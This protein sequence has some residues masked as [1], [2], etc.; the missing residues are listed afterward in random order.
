VLGLGSWR[1]LLAALVAASHLWAHMLQGYAAYAVWAFFVLS[2]YLMT[3]VLRDTY[4]FSVRGTAAY[5]WNR[6]LRIFPGYYAAL[7]T[8][9]LTLLVAQAFG[10]GFTGLNPEFFL[11]S[12]S[13][14]LN[15]LTLLTVF[16]RNGLPVAVSNALAVEV[17][18]YLTMPLLASSRAAALTALMLSAL[19]TAQL[20]FGL[21]SF[22]QRYSD[23]MPCMLAFATGSLLRH[24]DA[25]LRLIRAPILSLS[26]W[27]LHGAAWLWFPYWPWTYGLYVSLPLSGW[28]V[29]SLFPRRAGALDR[30]L[31]DLSYP[32][33]LFHTITG[34]WLIGW[35]HQQRSLGLFVA[36]FTLAVL[37]AWLVVRFIEQPLAALR[38]AR[39]L[40][41]LPAPRS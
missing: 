28:V 30:W 20:G 15:P 35:F 22:G 6:L 11:P 17:T 3:A 1:F 37:P 25:H 24:Y 38:A 39:P 19:F 18:A 29:I 13:A 31:G 23:F 7:L 27:L 16:P 12:G 10:T 32:V 8:G 26:L 14:W 33:Y 5:A 2:G 21:D 4:G 41:R 34:A 40:T 9:I 36:A